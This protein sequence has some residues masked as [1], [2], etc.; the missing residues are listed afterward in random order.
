MRKLE[1]ASQAL[2]IITSYLV[3]DPVLQK[4]LGNKIDKAVTTAPNV[5]VS[6][7]N[8]EHGLDTFITVTVSKCQRYANYDQF[9]Y[10]VG[11]GTA[12]ERQNPSSHVLE[13]LHRVIE[14]MTQPGIN[15]GFPTQFEF[16]EYEET[17]FDRNETA[18][19][20]VAMFETNDEKL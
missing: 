15:F 6:K 16:G 12:T 18:W 11:V 1:T 7:L 10:R 14:I 4:L 17:Y 5:N 13:I 2:D 19:G 9:F 20:Y 8:Q 3:N